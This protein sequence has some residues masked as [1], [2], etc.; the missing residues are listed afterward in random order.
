MGLFG[1]GKSFETKVKDAVE[2]VKKMNLGVRDFRASVDG[3]VVTLDGEADTVEIKG[4]LAQEF[5]RLITTENTFNKVRVVGPQ[6]APTAKPSA[7][8]AAAPGA[9]GR[10][11]IV[12]SG[13]T[14]SAL[15]Q[16]YYGKAGLYMKI[17]EAN[18]DILKDPNLIKIGQ[19]L[20]IPK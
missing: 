10:I 5:N 18:R 4:R 13:D 3:K 12:V 17:F 6:A 9:E 19:K 8:E 20:R 14:L 15:A 1:L 7:P 2:G 16:K 11:H